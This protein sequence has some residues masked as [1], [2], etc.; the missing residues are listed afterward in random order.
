MGAG[1]RPH[2]APPRER[3]VPH[4]HPRQP[5]RAPRLDPQVVRR[6]ARGD[7]RRRRGAQRAGRHHGRQPPRPARHRRRPDAEPRAHPDLQDPGRR[8][9]G[10]RRPRHR[11]AHPADPAPPV[12]AGGRD[13]P[14]VVLPGQGP[15]RPGHAAEQP[16]GL[17]RVRGVDPGRAARRRRDA[18]RPRR[19]AADLDP[20]DRPPRRAGADVLRLAAAQPGPRL[21]ADPAGHVEP[22]CHPLHG[23]D[24]RLLP[25]R[26]DPP[27]KRRC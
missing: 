1:R 12:P 8:L 13:R 7:P 14:G 22:A 6:P 9:E 21:G 5:G 18:P 20:L 26:R 2:P 23:R 16:A 17:A 3:R 10:G 25:A 27:S 4:L 11:G 15:L 19:Q 24:L